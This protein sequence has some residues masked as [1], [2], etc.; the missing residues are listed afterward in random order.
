MEAIFP[1]LQTLFDVHHLFYLSLG[2]ILGL[3]VGILP[4]LGGIA[5]LSLVL[6]F[7][8]DMQPSLALAMMI[9]L[10]SVTATSDTFP[11]VLIGVPGTSGSQAT[12]VDG[13]PL[14]KR[15]EATR[16]LSAAFSASLF[17]GC[18]GALVL[19]GAI[20]AARP[21]IL[22]IGFGEQMMLIVLA[23]SMVGMLT[24]EAAIKGLA[25][26][27]LGLLI[28][29]VGEAPAT[30]ELRMTLGTMYLSEGIPL[31]VVGLGIFALP[32]IVEVLAKRTTIST[33]GKLG[34]G[35]LQGLKDTISNR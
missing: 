22:M 30:A 1:A 29:V 10:T 3:I 25:V 5:G 34:K 21:I 23:L 15:G 13:F 20:F 26:C 2:V 32:E 17:G 8:Y 16:A 12:V 24:G 18:F 9:G 19:T 7:L 31:V 33:T 35:W 6:P 4:G 11:S 27:G 14:A 28:G